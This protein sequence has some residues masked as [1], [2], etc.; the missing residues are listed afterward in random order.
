MNT[1][2]ISKIRVLVN[3][4]K[5]NRNG[6]L[7]SG[8]EECYIC[9]RC[10]TGRFYVLPDGGS[11]KLVKIELYDDQSD[12]G[13]LYDLPCGTTVQNLGFYPVG[14]VCAKKV[15]LEFVGGGEEL[16]GEEPA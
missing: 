11:D 4:K 13:Y 15:P 8:N 1:Y 9:G 10:C 14:S 3:S 5:W 6:Y 16:F 2:D 7:G 12:G